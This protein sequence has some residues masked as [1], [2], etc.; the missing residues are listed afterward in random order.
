MLLAGRLE[1]SSPPGGAGAA[2]FRRGRVRSKRSRALPSGRCAFCGAPLLRRRFG[3]WIA[4]PAS[5]RSP[6]GR[7]W[8]SLG[9]GRGQGVCAQPGVGAKAVATRRERRIA[10]HRVPCPSRR[11]AARTAA[12]DR[13]ARR[14]IAR[15][16]DGDDAPRRAFTLFSPRSAPTLPPKNP[17]R[18]KLVC[19]TLNLPNPPPP[20]GSPAPTITRG[21]LKHRQ[22]R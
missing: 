20:P 15:F 19:P 7:R 12:C 16:F 5:L 17:S 10:P 21:A 14:P 1:A 22:W 11:F 18:I 2:L 6:V 4:R 3:H 13:A 9:V 8:R